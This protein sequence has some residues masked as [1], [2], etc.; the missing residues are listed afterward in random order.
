[1]EKLGQMKNFRLLFETSL[2]LVSVA[3]SPLKL[4][5]K[6]ASCFS[7]YL[8]FAPKGTE[9]LNFQYR[10]TRGRFSR[11]AVRAESFVIEVSG[12]LL[13]LLMQSAKVSAAFD[14]HSTTAPCVS[15]R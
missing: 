13:S 12:G 4:K 8:T 1:M 6:S 11:I 7:S 10:P 14:R 15:K 3:L 5:K 9:R 2:Y